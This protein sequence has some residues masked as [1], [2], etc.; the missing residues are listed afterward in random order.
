MARLALRV[1]CLAVYLLCSLVIEIP[2][3]EI[4]F[5]ILSNMSMC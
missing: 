1:L 3:D 4:L 5:L 2:F